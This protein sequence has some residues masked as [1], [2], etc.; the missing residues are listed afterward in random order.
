[1]KP[2]APILALCF[3][4]LIPFLT[5]YARGD[6]LKEIEKDI[7]VLEREVARIK[8]SLE[9]L[10]NTIISPEASRI[11]FYLDLPPG[12]PLPSSLK[13]YMNGDL[14]HETSFEG[15]MKGKNVIVPLDTYFIPGDY[16]IRVTGSFNGKTMEGK[17]G[18]MITL[19][20]G[21]TGK[22]VIS[23]TGK[24]GKPGLSVKNIK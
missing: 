1:M 21:E 18:E 17:T 3:A 19:K 11:I 13:I 12:S 2:R 14:A 6:S 20:P 8:K 4:I 22:I 10:G 23:K 5:G 16:E 24:K 7:L 15:S 9:I